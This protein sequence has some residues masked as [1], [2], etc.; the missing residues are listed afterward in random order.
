LNE[1]EKNSFAAIRKKLEHRYEQLSTYQYF[2]NVRSS[3]SKESTKSDID[4]KDCKEDEQ[5]VDIVSDRDGY[6]SDGSLDEY[7][8][9]VKVFDAS[10][11]TKVRRK[12]YNY[13]SFKSNLPSR[14]GPAN[15]HQEEQDEKVWTP[16]TNNSF[17]KLPE[18]LNSLDPKKV[19][20]NASKAE[21]SS[22]ESDAEETE[23]VGAQAEKENAIEIEDDLK[24]YVQVSPVEDVQNISDSTDSLDAELT[25]LTDTLEE[26]KLG[27]SIKL[28]DKESPTE[29]S[30]AISKE[31][32]GK[33]TAL[34]CEWD[35]ELFDVFFSGL[36]DE[37]QGGN[38]TWS[39]PEII[40][41]EEVEESKRQREAQSTNDLTLDRCLRLFSKPEVL[42]EQDLWYCSNCKE[43]RQATKQI[44][45]WSTPDILS[46]HLK[47][48]E[49]QRSF[50]D[51][52]DAVVD[53]PIEGLDMSPYL[54][55][56]IKSE[57][58]CIYDLFAVDNHF[59]GLG[60]GH[61]TS[62][63]KNFVDNQWYYY[64]DSRVTV[65][66]PEKA[67]APAA[68]LLFYRKRSH[69][70]LGGD[71][72]VET[73]EK[74]RESFEEQ[75]KLEVENL[76]N[77]YRE[78]KE[79]SSEEEDEPEEAEAEAEN[80]D[81]DD[82]GIEAGERNTHLPHRV[83]Y[84]VAPSPRKITE[85]DDE[86]NSSDNVSSIPVGSDDEETN[87]SSRRKQRLISRGSRYSRLAGVSA[88]NSDIDSPLPVSSNSTPSE[89]GST[90]SPP[91]NI[92]GAYPSPNPTSSPK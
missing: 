48:F 78:N 21:A 24:D 54:A 59:G 85:S 68:Y 14:Y 87:F 25:V 66:S 81:G 46:I 40:V 23:N 62:Y 37:G 17:T 31:L 42:G 51:K 6:D 36:E 5:D 89:D 91:V 9:K 67:I 53:F 2:S 22:K 65:S 86:S 49:N 45:I 18:L 57:D 13:A 88:I 72:L 12:N 15:H 7:A 84:G 10:K 34:V 3:E 28:S 60:G 64:D 20:L 38:N 4:M 19:A 70:F 61:Y 56:T 58:D 76:E 77:F 26:E 73:L 80:D 44:E 75:Q 29:R 39:N 79:S 27:D 83:A 43:H 1:S 41:N 71:N 50:S 82:E 35:P 90:Y 8:F 55:T 74:A 30:A 47:R 92:P 63:V 11:S 16:N 33:R 52:I 32:I 69:K